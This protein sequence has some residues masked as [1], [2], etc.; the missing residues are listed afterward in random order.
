[1][2]HLKP[3]VLLFGFLSVLLSGC[4]KPPVEEAGP[5]SRPVKSMVVSAPSGSGVRNFPG[6]VDSANKAD[7]SFRV[8]GTVAKLEVTEGERVKRGDTLAQLDQTDFLIALK[9]RQATFDQAD[10]D[11]GRARE[12][13]DRGAISRRD[14]DT[15]EATFKTA[16]A[17]LEQAQQNVDYTILRAPFDGTIAE[18]HVDAFEEVVAGLT[19]IFSIATLSR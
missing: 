11:Y 5:V 9:D 2:L 14:F 3:L 6:R 10:K 17:A 15:V 1:M 12:L 13:V 7:L 16:Q 18:R 4:A 19:S 8:S